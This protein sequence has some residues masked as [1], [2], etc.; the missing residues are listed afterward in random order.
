MIGDYLLK[1]LQVS[2]SRRFRNIILV[3]HKDNIPA[4]NKPIRDSLEERKLKPKNEKYESQKAA[5]LAGN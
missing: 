1:A 2:Q 4:Y 5:K 3:I